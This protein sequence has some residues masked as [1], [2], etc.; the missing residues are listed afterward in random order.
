VAEPEVVDFSPR[1]AGRKRLV[2]AGA[3]VGVI[4]V[5]AVVVLVGIRPGG[6]GS[7]AGQGDPA[8]AGLVA[9]VT[10]VPAAVSG[11]TVDGLSQVTARVTGVT[12][13]PLVAGGKPEVFYVGTEYCPFCAAQGWALIV[14]LG[15]FGTFSGLRTIRSG[16]YQPYP[17]LAAWT[18]YGSAYASRYLTFVAVE[19]KS[20]VLTTPK[21]DPQ[22][23]S[24]YTAL[25][26]LTAAQQ[27]VFSRY[28]Q[29]R[30]VPFLDFGNRSVIVGASFD[31]LVLQRLT[32]SQIAAQLRQ[33]VSLTGWAVLGTANYL[34][35]ALCQ[36]TGDQPASVCTPAITGLLAG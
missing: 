10:G 33:P 17:Y 27:A 6:S 18:F 21:A 1:G 8:P 24:S 7:A 2:V 28:D 29:A 23:G 36:L 19:T 26:K 20:N 12:G 35:A 22:H 31:P 3:V 14:A 25:Q 9:Q 34:T 16:N 11:V 32:W 15:R 4:V 5:A 13:S 30:S